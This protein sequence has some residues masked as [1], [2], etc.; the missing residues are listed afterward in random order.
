[1]KKNL[2]RKNKHRRNSSHVELGPIPK[3]INKR[4]LEER[5]ATRKIRT[6]IIATLLIFLSPLWFYR[7][8]MHEIVLPLFGKEIKAV[9]AGTMGKAWGGRRVIPHYYYSFYEKGKLYNKNSSISVK[10]TLYHIGD[11][12]NIIYLKAFPFISSRIDSDK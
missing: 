12:V 5:A 11:T 4:I 7:G 1:M 6:I 9:L 8:V 3:K 10:D 2:R